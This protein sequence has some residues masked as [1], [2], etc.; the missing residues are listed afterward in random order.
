MITENDEGVW[1]VFMRGG[2]LVAR[3]P[4][5]DCK[6]VGFGFKQRHD[7]TWVRPCCMRRE[8]AAYERL[9][10]GPVHHNPSACKFCMSETR[11]A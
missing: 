3:R 8:R 6:K 10:G 9:G 1:E 5:C 11:K 2:R 7:G 4:W